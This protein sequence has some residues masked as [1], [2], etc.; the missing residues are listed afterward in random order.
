MLADSSSIAGLYH[1]L[2]V[3]NRLVLPVFSSILFLVSSADVLH[4]FTIPS[5]GIKVDA[6]PGR[7]NYLVSL[8]QSYGVYYGQCSEICGANHRFMPICAEFVS[9]D[10]FISHIS[11][12]LL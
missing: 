4:S 6:I 11:S 10:S 9:I 2:D 8:V 5:L 3:D 1:N 12:Q 7:L